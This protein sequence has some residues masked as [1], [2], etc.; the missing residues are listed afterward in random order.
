MGPTARNFKEF[1]KCKRSKKNCLFRRKCP[2]SSG[3]LRS[4]LFAAEGNHP[5]KSI[6]GPKGS[7][8][9]AGILTVQKDKELKASYEKML[10]IQGPASM[11]YEP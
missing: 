4:A 9:I 10:N 1:T 2:R 7:E 8:P 11:L 3:Q 6:N 5:I